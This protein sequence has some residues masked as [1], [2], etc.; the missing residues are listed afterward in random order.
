VDVINHDGSELSAQFLQVMEGANPSLVLCPGEQVAEEL[1]ALD[2]ARALD[3][4]RALER[5]EAGTALAAVEI[6]AGFAD[7]VRAFEAVEVVAHIK[8]GVTLPESLQQAF[9]AARAQVGGAVLAA[10]VGLAAAEEVRGEPLDGEARSQWE[11]GIYGRATSLWEGKP[12]QVQYV[13][14]A[15]PEGNP[16]LQALERGLGHS[17]P[18]MGSM[19]VL[20]TVLGGMTTLAVERK[21][22]TLQRLAVMPISS[23]QLLGGKIL[24]RFSLGVL[25]FLVVFAV[26][27]L[28]GMQFGHDPLG[29]V[30]TVVAYT[31]AATALSFAL[32]SWVQNEAQA[33]GLALLLSITLS[34]LGGAWW[35]LEIVPEFM[36]VIGHLSPVAWAMESF[37]ELIFEGGGLVDIV[38]SLGVLFALAGLLFL[39]GARRF[40]YV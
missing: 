13:L 1:C 22:W 25:Q 18:G 31:L 12:V 7:A 21:Q 10:H 14:T 38:P 33:S 40:R 16:T 11:A 9:E 34:P 17:V 35:P 2:G 4:A 23:A 30:A 15:Q 26:G 27:A 8:G 3:L 29:L 5:V 6:P 39:V 20:L 32:G 36:R 24:A 37:T 28:L 19:F